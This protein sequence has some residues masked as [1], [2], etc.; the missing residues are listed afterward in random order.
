MHKV[1]GVNKDLVCCAEIFIDYNGALWDRNELK[2]QLLKIIKG[3]CKC[4]IKLIQQFN[5]Q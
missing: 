1:D 4:D 5:E 2:W 3:V